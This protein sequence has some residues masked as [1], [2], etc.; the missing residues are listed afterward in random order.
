MER[1]VEGVVSV[2]DLPAFS[3]SLL[4]SHEESNPGVA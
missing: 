3:V 4:A 1:E 2:V